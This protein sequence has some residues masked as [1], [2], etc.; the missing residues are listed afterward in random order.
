[1]PPE[2][3]RVKSPN[4]EH[5][6][7]SKILVSRDSKVKRFPKQLKHF[8]TQVIIRPALKYVKEWGKRELIR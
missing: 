3:V 4:I 2:S 7:H 6:G 5:L 8:K 1:M